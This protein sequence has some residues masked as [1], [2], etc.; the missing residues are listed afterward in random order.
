MP[1]LILLTPAQ[2]ANALSPIVSS[3]S[4]NTSPVNEEQL[5]KAVFPIVLSLL[6]KEKLSI[7]VNDANALLPIVSTFSQPSTLFTNGHLTKHISPI[8]LTF[9]PITIFSILGHTSFAKDVLIL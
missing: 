1:K 9:L 8:Y 5:V 6:P 2:P 4:G 7:F 3:V